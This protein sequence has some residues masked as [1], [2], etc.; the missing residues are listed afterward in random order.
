MSSTNR[1][2]SRHTAD[3]Y[4][5]PQN[6]IEKFLSAFLSDMENA[7]EIIGT[8]PDKLLWIDTCAGGDTQNE[9]S[10]PAVIQGKMGLDIETMD[11]RQDSLANIKENYLTQKMSGYDVFI[12]NPPF[13]LAKE[14]I[15]KALNEV[16]DNGYV[17]ML[18]RLNFL[19]SKDRFDFITNNMP[20]YI[21][22]HHKRMS[23]TKDKATDSIE[24]AHFVWKKGENPLFSKLSVI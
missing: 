22:V 6:E 19:G 16:N 14:I 17:I 1:G 3:Y 24:Y 7:D 12:T 13:Y 4:V 2:Y 10:Y 23:F 11:I 8:R 5:T 20:S 9:M 18:L 15:Q 21:Y